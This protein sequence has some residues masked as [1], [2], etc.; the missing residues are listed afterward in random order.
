MKSKS[1]KE[2]KRKGKGKIGWIIALI[3]VA[4]LG[5]G[6]VI[7]WTFLTREHNE[8]KNLPLDSMDF[9]KLNDGTYTG[10]Y[11]GEIYK[12]RVNAAGGYDQ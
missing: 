4:V 7:G 3:I 12:W 1:E 8:A 2:M 5:I 10:E 11:E 6:G 9:S